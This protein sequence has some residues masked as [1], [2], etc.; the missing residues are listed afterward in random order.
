M[1]PG[2]THVIGQ[3]LPSLGDTEVNNSS[4]S[5]QTAHRPVEETPGLVTE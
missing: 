4:P 1:L 5:L 2:L 3:V